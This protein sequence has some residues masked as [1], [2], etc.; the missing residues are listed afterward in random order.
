MHYLDELKDKR[1]KK[2]LLFL[3]NQRTTTK[4]I[5]KTFNSTQ[6]QTLTNSNPT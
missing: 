2:F 4:K 3:H 5:I 6:K 1:A